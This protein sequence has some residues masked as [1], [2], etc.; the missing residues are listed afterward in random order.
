MSKD[1][2]L[3]KNKIPLKIL[4]TLSDFGEKMTTKDIADFLDLKSSQVSGAL[5]NLQKSGLV[6]VK[7]GT[8]SVKTK[9]K[10]EILGKIVVK[11]YRYW[12]NPRF[13][14]DLQ[15]L[16]TPEEIDE[17]HPQTPKPETQCKYYCI[18]VSE[19]KEPVSMFLFSEL[20]EKMNNQHNGSL[21]L[22][23]GDKF[24]K[25]KLVEIIKIEVK[26]QFYLEP[27]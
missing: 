5:L 25:M 12:I 16:L 19:N 15:K 8:R 13:D 20:N 11:H 26:K 7:K 9:R 24:Y 6:F 14:F 22:S 4:E 21:F 10:D 1:I 23:D 2:I 27:K 3:H 18:Q 17:P